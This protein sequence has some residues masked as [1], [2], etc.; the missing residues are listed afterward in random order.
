[1]EDTRY[2]IRQ[3]R[4]LAN[5]GLDE[6][7]VETWKEALSG[8]YASQDY[9]GMFVLSGN[10]GEACVQI[11]MQS[12]GSPTASK[13][14]QEA[15]QN[16]DY[17]LQI[18]EQC[19]LRDVLGGYRVLYQ[20]VRRAEALKRKAQKLINTLQSVEKETKRE[21]PPCTTCEGAEKEAI[22]DEND[23]CYYCK[24]CFD[25]YYA[26][27]PVPDD[28]V[29]DEKKKKVDAGGVDMEDRALH[30]WGTAQRDDKDDGGAEVVVSDVSPKSKLVEATEAAPV[31]RDTQ[32]AKVARDEI[33]EI[34]Q[35]QANTADKMTQDRVRYERV[36]LGSLADILAGKLNS[37]NASHELE[38]QANTSDAG[39]FL[40]KSPSEEASEE[41]VANTEDRTNETKR[42]AKSDSTPDKLEYSI[43]QLLGIRKISP[44]EC[45]NTLF[46]SPV[47]DDGTT[48]TP[49]HMKPNNSRK[50]SNAKKTSRSVSSHRQ[51][52]E[53]ATDPSQ[54]EG[55][56]KP[57]ISQLPTLELCASMRKALLEHNEQQTSSSATV[58]NPVA[59]G[60]LL[61]EHQR[62]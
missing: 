36:E 11:A 4:I 13:L 37:E 47:R 3:G 38:D 57:T 55:A 7:A 42:S 2:A 40:T 58:D 19:S 12:K 52:N 5:E 61:Q 34:A 51:N 46:K 24:R 50:K 15:V 29:C 18:V 23:G 22:L 41:F 30:G 39:V 48:P 32:M 45:P 60:A 25:E 9:A 49:A 6:H 28:L 43:A 17:A 1:M 27:T 10:I 44:R 33:S 21:V 54:A 14:L 62:S 31:S 8:A 56:T 20:G 26:T 16:L 53:D 59:A 35:V